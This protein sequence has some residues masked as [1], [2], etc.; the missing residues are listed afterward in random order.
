[1]KT[2]IEDCQWLMLLADETE[3]GHFLHIPRQQTSRTSN[4]YRISGGHHRAQTSPSEH[5]LHGR[6]YG[7]RQEIWRGSKSLSQFSDVKRPR[8][9]CS[10]DLL[11]MVW[12]VGA[13]IRQRMRT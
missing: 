6:T 1:M 10:A 13:F 5:A 11:T 4:A 2:M 9:I 8:R 3:T 12:R 7:R